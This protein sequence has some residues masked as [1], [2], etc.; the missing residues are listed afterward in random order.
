MTIKTFLLKFFLLFFVFISLKCFSQP[1]SPVSPKNGIVIN[2]DSILLRWNK[3]SNAQFYELKYTTDS[4]F[5]NNITSIN[6]GLQTAYWL[7]PLLSN[8]TYYWRVE[9]NTGAATVIGQARKFTNFKPTDL[10]GCALWLRADTGLT[11]SGNNVQGWADASSNNFNIVQASA[12]AQPQL[13]TNTIAG[14]PSLSF[15]GN[16]IFV[17]NNFPYGSFNH[18]FIVAKKTNTT[19][20]HGIIISGPNFDFEMS[21]LRCAVNY[22]GILGSNFDAYKWTQISLKRKSGDSKVVINGVQAGS[23]DVATLNPVSIGNLAIGNRNPSVNSPGPL[24]GNVSEIIINTSDLN[25]FQTSSIQNYLMDKYTYELSAGRDTNIADNFC[26]ISISAT[27]GFTNYLWSTGD[28]SASITVSNS[29]V[30]YVQALDI[31][32]RIHIDTIVVTYPEVSQ[33]NFNVLCEGSQ[34]NWNTNLSSPYTFLW[35]DNSTASNFLISQPGVYYVKVTDFLGCNF[36]SDTIDL[37]LDNFPAVAFIGNDTMLC[38]GNSLQ[39]QIGANVATNY[40]WSNGS[41]N[42]S[43]F[44]TAGGLFWLEVSNINNCIARDTINISLTGIAPVADF[45]SNS[46]CIGLPTQFTDLSTAAPGDSI[47][48]WEWSFADGNQSNMQNPVN[49]YLTT[50][51]YIVTLKAISQTSC[52][53]IVNKLVTV[54]PHPNV[55]FT[56]INNCNDKQTTF[57]DITNAFGGTITNWEW[58]F[59]DTLSSTNIG[60]GNIESHSYLETGNYNVLLVVSTLEGCVDSIIKPIFI[61]PSPIAAFNYSKLC[62]GDSVTFQDVSLISFPHQNILREWTFNDSLI[63]TKYQPSMWYNIS[64]SYPVNLIIMASNGCRDTI[65]QNIFL[66]NLP[67]SDF[68]FNAPCLGDLT[69]FNDVSS[70][71]NCFIDFRQW[72][73]NGVVISSADSANYIFND[74]GVY[75]I[76]LEVKNTAG[77]ASH[78]EKS[79]T[80][81]PSPVASFSSSGLFGSP[82][83]VI[84]F[85]NSS[86]NAMNYNWDFGDGNSSEIFEPTHT[87]EDTGT[88]FIVLTAIDSNGCVSSANETIRILPRKIDIALLDANFQIDNNYIY[89]DITFINLGS[90][91][92]K[93]FNIN[94]A[95]NG[96]PNNSVEKWD[97]TLL[98]GEIKNYRLRTSFLNETFY[99]TDYL[100]INLSALDQGEDVNL[101][102]NELC[103]T[104]DEAGFKIANIYPN[105]VNDFLNLSLLVPYTKEVTIQVV[106]Y[107]G[108][109][110]HQKLIIMEKGFN[111]V[112]IETLNLHDGPYLLRVIFEGNFF[113]KTFIKVESK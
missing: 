70:C 22:G 57:S 66:S 37:V 74:E 93:A 103:A 100:C 34:I 71:V 48:S 87:F 29:G 1:L 8:T 17:L 11:L 101:K 23:G 16:D 67:N 105:P 14:F 25:G 26:P 39:L 90:I 52:A 9:A 83:M 92:I 95:S 104:L 89:T 79:I 97:G 69:S 31:F 3:L 46:V 56:V 80:I 24:R 18:G 5:I 55:N 113:L 76:N 40:L 106:D 85:D 111:A 98:P 109:I 58:N 91:T 41:A 19:V 6:V 13:Q 75:T 63:S 10:L 36:Y 47:I 4:S 27:S 35:Q 96:S 45:V 49:T 60:L 7:T 77:C 84:S 54:Y 32:D 50:N 43:L 12:T 82:P 65:S 61:K 30:F 2:N 78:I 62:V 28:T 73:L 64:G 94:M 86:I 110:I 38:T 107:K 53:G 102:N 112:S 15:D 108:D 51:N 88:F 81:N 42:D 72:T 21:T 99:P 59:N 20:T 44:I 68:T 33:L